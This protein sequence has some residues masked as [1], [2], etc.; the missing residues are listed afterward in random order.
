MTALLNFE[1]PVAVLLVSV[2]HHMGDQD[3][4]WA[5]TAQVVD[6]M[7]AGSALVISHFSGDSRPEEMV[8]IRELTEPTGLRVTPRSRSQIQRLFQ[9]VDL[10]HPGLVRAPHW[11]PDQTLEAD[12]APAV[13]SSVLAGVGYKR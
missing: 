5:T 11:R 12:S 9:G 2:L 8:R 1:K 13:P 7:V 10:V 4:P 6:R 3:D